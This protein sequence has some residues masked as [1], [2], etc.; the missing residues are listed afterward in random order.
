MKKKFFLLRHCKATGQNPK[1][2]LS[3][4]GLRQS[5]LIVPR[6]CTLKIDGII[7]SSYERAVQTI[8]PFSATADLSMSIDDR[9]CERILT[10]QDMP[11]WKQNLE[12]TFYQPAL[13][14]AGGE[15]SEEARRRIV[16]C[17]DIWSG[18]YESPV[19]VS[20]GNIIIIYLQSL[21]ASIGFQHWS[22]MASPEL[23]EVNKSDGMVRIVWHRDLI[24]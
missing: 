1:A 10:T 4:E 7:S 13:K 6:L 8:S 23:I 12:A 5:E 19:F 17:V 9:L 20:H 14:F 18:K 24:G 2:P 3:P 15:S 22:E 11:D 21:D 16:D